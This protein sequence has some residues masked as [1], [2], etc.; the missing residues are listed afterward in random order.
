VDDKARGMEWVFVCERESNWCKKMDENWKGWGGGGG[1][2]GEGEI[3]KK[4]KLKK[5]IK[6]EEDA[7]TQPLG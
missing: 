1:G 2:G 5:L 4:K 7:T 6:N 3:I